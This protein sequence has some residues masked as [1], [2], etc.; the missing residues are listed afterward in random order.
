MNSLAKRV[1]EGEKKLDVLFVV[2]AFEGARA[3]AV[4]DDEYGTKHPG[5]VAETVAVGEV[6]KI[7][8]EAVGLRKHHE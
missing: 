3:V 4:D 6:A 1:E 7:D 2:F 8:D 5:Q